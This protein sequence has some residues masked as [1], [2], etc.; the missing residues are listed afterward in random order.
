MFEEPTYIEIFDEYCPECKKETQ[1]E[2]RY[3]L[4]LFPY[5]ETVVEGI[6][7][8]LECGYTEQID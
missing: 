8:C 4:Y 7:I 6:K 2:Y 5:Q 3:N 1:F